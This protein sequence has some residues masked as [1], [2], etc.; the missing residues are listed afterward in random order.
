MGL[1]CR[2]Y[3][4][5]QRGCKGFR[6]RIPVRTSVDELEALVEKHLRAWLARREQVAWPESKG[7]PFRGLEPFDRDPSPA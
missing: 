6:S 1:L 2:E 3:S 5:F 7:S 4:D